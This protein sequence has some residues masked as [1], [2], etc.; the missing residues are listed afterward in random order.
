MG[1]YLEK[2]VARKREE[3]AVA[4]EAVSQADLT[5]MVADAPP[6]LPFAM[7]VV[8]RNGIIAEFKRRSPSKGEIHSGAIS[9]R[10]VVPAYCKAGVSA[11][12]CLTDADF[13][14]GSLADLREA[15]SVAKVPVLR[16]EFV[17]DEYQVLEARAHGASAILLIAAILSQDEA[18]HL[19]LMAKQLGMEVLMEL[20][21]EDEVG[22]VSEGVTVAGIN[23][24]D[25]RTFKV[26]LDHSIRVAHMLPASL[27]RIS[28][29]GI[30]G[31]DDMV[32][33]RGAGF[34]GFL[35]GECFMREA[36]P[37]AA[38]QRLCDDYAAARG[39]S[40]RTQKRKKWTEK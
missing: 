9:P 13:F 37:G 20:H 30:G 36:N 23:N 39:Q 4:K 21:N 18:R 15:A 19:A 27:P 16:K 26:D 12:S 22:Y 8:E 10:D 32:K 2:I 34:D 35:I 31:V 1:N 3:V 28:E 14:G 6:P 5:A 29:S 7:S 33:L 38:C 17:I 11:I 40:D 25:L 24:R